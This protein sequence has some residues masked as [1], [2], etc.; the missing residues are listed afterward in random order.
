MTS[1]RLEGQLWVRLVHPLLQRRGHNA[2]NFTYFGQNIERLDAQAMPAHL[3]VVRGVQERSR[4]RR[5]HTT[6][7]APSKRRAQRSQSR[8]PGCRSASN[9]MGISTALT[10]DVGSRARTSSNLAHTVTW[11]AWASRASGC[12]RTT[13]HPARHPSMPAKRAQCWLAHGLYNAW[14]ASATGL[15]RTVCQLTSPALT[16][17]CSRRYVQAGST[18][19]NWRGNEPCAALRGCPGTFSHRCLDIT[20]PPCGNE[21]QGACREKVCST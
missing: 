8:P 20:Q 2:I 11:C 12:A 7:P 4:R 6:G 16:L 5:E 18:P 10:A 13:T 17:T 15:T 21:T 3:G 14:C 19:P 1:Q 9:P